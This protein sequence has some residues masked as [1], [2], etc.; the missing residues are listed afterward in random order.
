MW[1]LFCCKFFINDPGIHNSYSR[2]LDY[3]IG[4]ETFQ[5]SIDIIRLTQISKFKKLLCISFSH[6]FAQT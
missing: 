4:S 5:I 2:D 1:G 3:S 6:N